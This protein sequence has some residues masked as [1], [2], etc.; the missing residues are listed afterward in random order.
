MIIKFFSHTKK[1]IIYDYWCTSAY[2]YH[3]F[4]FDTAKQMRVLV[5]WI[6]WNHFNSLL[7]E[8]I[9]INF[10]LNYGLK[11]HAIQLSII[12][13]FWTSLKAFR[14]LFFG[15][16]MSLNPRVLSSLQNGNRAQL[17]AH[18]CREGS[19]EPQPRVGCTQQRR[20]HAPPCMWVS[21]LR[22][23]FERKPLGV[24]C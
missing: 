4:V 12:P 9:I 1:M 23:A 2:I 11:L 14:V 18:G 15:S 19:H 21:L 3:F 24:G 20:L 13:L 8:V 6:P 17:S 7:T 10:K 16:R 5:T 22:Y